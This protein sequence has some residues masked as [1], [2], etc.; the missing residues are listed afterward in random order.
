MLLLYAENHQ[1]CRDVHCCSMLMAL[2][3]R[4]WNFQQ[5]SSGLLAGS[6]DIDETPDP[7]RLNQY[8]TKS[9]IAKAT[10]SPK[11]QILPACNEEVSKAALSL[12]SNVV[13]RTRVP[14]ELI[15]MT[16]VSHYHSSAY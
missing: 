16:V 12:S 4:E 9:Q 3:S 8:L 11:R 7:S 6:Q 13:H 14:A 1:L 5:E 15:D 10:Q 2:I